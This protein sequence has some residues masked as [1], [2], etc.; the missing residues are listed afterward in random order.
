[1]NPNEVPCCNC[2]KIARVDELFKHWIWIRQGEKGEWLCSTPCLAAR[3]V[4]AFD[5]Q[6]Q[7]RWTPTPEEEERM[8]Q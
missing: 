3:W 8:K 1:M 5:C 2:G 6:V 7:I 4:T